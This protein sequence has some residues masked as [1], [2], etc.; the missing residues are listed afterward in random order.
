MVVPVE[1]ERTVVVK[2]I[3]FRL[4]KSIES[5]VA[6]IVETLCGFSFSLLMADKKVMMSRR[7]RKHLRSSA[8]GYRTDVSKKFFSN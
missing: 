8:D 3:A 1:K 6:F 4:V 2:S 5:F 7:K